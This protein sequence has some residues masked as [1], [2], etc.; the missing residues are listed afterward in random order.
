MCKSRL[1]IFVF[2][3]AFCTIVNPLRGQTNTVDVSIRLDDSAVKAIPIDARQ[4]LS[5]TRDN[6]PEAAELIAAAPPQ[7]AIPVIFLA[8]GALSIPVIWDAI[9]EMV[10]E[11]EYGGVIIDT[12]RRPPEVTNNK[13]I[14][15][16]FVFVIHEDG[17][18]EKMES[19]L[20]H[21]PRWENYWVAE[22]RFRGS[23]S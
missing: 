12:R 22:T 11:T 19:R 18:T 8:V 5:I 1:L 21:V 16:G 10:R 15:A 6:S 13:K 3:S 20:F 4:N 23:L 7:K 2:F 14:P 9:L 17:S